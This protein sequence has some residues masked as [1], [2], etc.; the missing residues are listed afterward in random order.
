[1]DRLKNLLWLQLPTQFIPYKYIQQGLLLAA[2]SGVYIFGFD[3]TARWISNSLPKFGGT[4]IT[5]ITLTTLLLVVWKARTILNYAVWRIKPKMQDETYRI[6]AYALFVTSSYFFG[7]SISLVSIEYI[8]IAFAVFLV[9]A[10]IYAL[11][12]AA[13]YISQLLNPTKPESMPLNVLRDRP[14]DEEPIASQRQTLSALKSMLASAYKQEGNGALAIALDGAY[15]DGKS[16]IV[17]MALRSLSAET[18]VIVHF[19][20]WRYTSQ[21]ALV[22]GFYSEIGKAVEA[23]LP[24]FQSS[25]LD[26]AKF[27]EGF[28]THVDKT[29]LVK[30]FLGSYK[31]KADDYPAKVNRHLERHGRKLLVVIDDVDRIDEDKHVLRTLQLAQYLKSDIERSVILFMAEMEIVKEAIPARMRKAYLQKFFDTTIMA[32]QPQ[33]HEMVAFINEKLKLLTF[34]CDVQ[35]K[36]DKGLLRLIR[37]MRG[38]KRVL[39]MLASD[40]EGIGENVNAQDIFFMRVLYYAF[41]VIYVDIRDNAAMYYEYNY[42]F[43]D[44]DFGVYGLEEEG[45]EADQRNHFEELLNTLGMSVLDK[46]RLKS[47]LEGY[48]PHLKNVFRDPGLGKTRIDERKLYRERRIGVRDYL[49]RYF[50]F[51]ENVDKRHESEDT[52]RQFL[53]EVYMQAPKEK[54]V[55]KLVE[56]YKQHGA[57]SPRLFFTSLLSLVEDMHENMEEAEKVGLYRDIL[58]TCFKVTGYLV[59]DND[60]SLTRILGAINRLLPRDA[61]DQ[62]FEDVEQ[63]MSHPS[64]GLRLLLY[65]NPT[66]DNHFANLQG[67]QGYSRLRQRILVRVDNYYLKE[68]NNPFEEDQSEEREWRFVLYQWATSVC[69]NREADLVA[70][71]RIQV[72]EYIVNLVESNLA[73]LHDFIM[74]AF[75]QNDLISDKHRFMFDAKPRAY[76]AERFI[77]VVAGLLADT[78]KADELTADQRADFERFLDQYKVYE[79]DKRA[80]NTPTATLENDE[81][82]WAT[83]Y[84]GYGASFRAVL[85]IDNFGGKAD[86]LTDVVVTGDLTDGNKWRSNIFMFERDRPREPLHIAADEILGKQVFITDDPTTGRQM[87]ELVAGT[88]RLELTFRSG[89]SVSINPRSL[90]KA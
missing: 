4:E 83:N 12:I 70:E 82:A 71:R 87:P 27:A 65:I 53:K 19:E 23:Q 6:L 10:A 76:E 38:A 1:M 56:L 66:R 31:R 36:S 34:Q 15:G 64:T 44:R 30:A 85:K 32:S 59:R 51:S 43:N 89:R 20:P 80:A 54:R 55:D 48:F 88:V 33:D 39:S 49:D 24:G 42:D 13:A 18:Y 67:Y 29:G 16:S 14:H 77:E 61:L 63:Y 11:Y 25:R 79:R 60:G 84:G 50:T 57:D 45:F 52:I 47:L 7:V 75:W 41:P 26:M 2:M 9:T 58:R 86:Y 17:R 78:A 21:E 72:N 3:Y 40:I 37:N 5:L 81:L 35:L 46:K 69:H 62:I 28:I 68:G 74:G 90:R 8:E 22:S 73:Q